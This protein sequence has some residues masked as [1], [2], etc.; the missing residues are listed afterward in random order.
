MVFN[1]FSIIFFCWAFGYIFLI[2]NFIELEMEIDLLV[3]CE[4]HEFTLQRNVIN[5]KCKKIEYWK[6]GKFIGNRGDVNTYAMELNLF[7]W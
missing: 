5:D 2:D 4:T 3:N 7:L 6:C 1:T